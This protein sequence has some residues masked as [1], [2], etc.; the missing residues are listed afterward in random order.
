M[1]FAKKQ[2]ATEQTVSVL[3][4]STSGSTSTAPSQVQSQPAAITPPAS[5]SLPSTFRK[6]G[7]IDTRGRK[8][9]RKENTLTRMQVTESIS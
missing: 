9:E 4:D 7:V 2:K 5:K 6:S 8:A 1:G 3:K